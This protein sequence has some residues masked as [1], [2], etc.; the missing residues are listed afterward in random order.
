MNRCCLRIAF[1]AVKGIPFSGGIELYTAEV[2]SRLAAAGHRVTV[3]TTR[4]YGNRTG[5]HPDGYDIIAM[6]CPQN[7]HLEK[8]VLSLKASLHQIFARYDIVHYQAMGASLFS[9]LAKAS[10]KIVVIQSHGIE[11]KR[12]KWGRFESACLRWIER[13]SL[14]FADSLVVVSENLCRHFRDTYGRGAVY[15]PTG[16]DPAVFKELNL[17]K[18]HGL[19][20]GGYFLFMARLVPEKG[21]HHLIKAFRRLPTDK[22]LVI[23]GSGAPGD[24][25][26][27]E[28][29]ELAAGDSRIVFTGNVSG[30]EKQELLTGAYAFVH[31]SELE[32]L[33]IA[34]LE[35][36]S[37]K[38][39]CIV[40]DIPE[41]M[42]IAE[43]R[44][45]SFVNGNVQD[46]TNKLALSLGIGRQLPE[47]G[48]TAY[49]FALKNHRWD[50]I[51]ERLESL[52]SDLTSARGG[53]H[54]TALNQAGK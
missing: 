40:S 37:Y 19:D 43:G 6:R 23:A 50:N 46:L 1:I 48:E 45:I 54:A 22:K 13:F 28:L 15:I 18:K 53:R 25:Y 8:L 34:L 16:I 39:C 7:R 3:Y 9:F 27:R 47:I 14:V 24:R 26:E 31:P 5:A 38:K 2:A 17:M 41:N 30:V 35:A 52:Y 21:A 20:D 29:R 4:N 49:E 12:A 32:G 44:S 11:Y 33:S 42:E 51:A 10:G 36:M